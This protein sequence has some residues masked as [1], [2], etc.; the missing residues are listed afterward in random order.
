MNRL[1]MLVDVSHLEDASFWDVMETATQP[2]IAT[3]SNARALLEGSCVRDLSDEQIT[4]IAES[5]GVVGA[6][7]MWL[8]F[9]EEATS[10]ETWLNNVDHMV[11]L[12][13]PDHVG[14]G[15]DFS[16]EGNYSPTGFEDISKIP[17]FIEGLLKRGHSDDTVKKILG[18]NFVRVFRA[19]VG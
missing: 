19:V 5:G 18:G 2:V 8:C 3:H 11:G 13:G 7:A 4:A 10:L 1:G 6:T 15:T 9:N 14:F 12:V 17:A 16:G